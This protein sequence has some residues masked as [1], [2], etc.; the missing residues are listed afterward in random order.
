MM[1]SVDCQTINKA[2]NDILYLANNL[3]FQTRKH[4]FQD[5]Q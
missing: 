5:F 1:E 3:L 2:M 4:I